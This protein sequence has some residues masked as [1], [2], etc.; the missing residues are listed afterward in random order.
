MSKKA[1]F[2][3]LVLLSFVL[4]SQCIAAGEDVNKTETLRLLP[5]QD[6][7][8]AAAAELCLKAETAFESGQWNEAVGLY[9]DALFKDPGNT[10]AMK[11]LKQVEKAVELAETPPQQKLGKGAVKTVDRTN[12]KILEQIND[13]LKTAAEKVHGGNYAAAIACYGEVLA[14][15]PDNRVALRK[16]RIVGEM[17]EKRKQVDDQIAGLLTTAETLLKD[18]RF[19]QAIDVYT[20]ILASLDPVNASAKKGIELAKHSKALAVE[21][22]RFE[23]ID[24]LLQKAALYR[25]NGRFK[26]AEELYREVLAR[27]TFNVSAQD[28]LKL[29]QLEKKKNRTGT[30]RAGPACRTVKEARARSPACE[31]G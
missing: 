1:V 30:K 9:R 28:G 25:K 13:K 27:D 23:Y 10:R 18:G 31:A 15:D 14:L 24:K 26:D 29:I 7:R 21:K 11:G 22:K 2:G 5:N 4:V 20:E 19:D 8:A 3:C 17:Y 6:P 16:M 12:W